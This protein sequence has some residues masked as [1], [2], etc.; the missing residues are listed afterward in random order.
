MYPWYFNYSF[1]LTW[2][3]VQVTILVRICYHWNPNYD[4]NEEQSPMLLIDYQ[5]YFLDDPK[6]DN[7][8]VQ[9]CMALHYKKL[10]D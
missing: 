8:F 6:H 4:P 10:I 5:Y 1:N 9:H 7:L 3:N 2:Y